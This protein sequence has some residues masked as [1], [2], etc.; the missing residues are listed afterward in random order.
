MLTQL[1]QVNRLSPA[2]FAAQEAASH[3]AQMVWLCASQASQETPPRKT[4]RMEECSRRHGAPVGGAHGG[5]SCVHYCHVPSSAT[6][7]KHH[8]G[9]NDQH[10]NIETNKH[11]SALRTLLV[12]CAYLLIIAERSS[13]SQI[14][15]QHKQK[16][17]TSRTLSP[18]SLVCTLRTPTWPSDTAGCDASS[19]RPP[20]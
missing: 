16:N 2:H 13:P 5:Q 19:L 9:A 6:T 17:V 11:T 3:R 14:D 4:T 1:D 18:A 10:A 20:L 12:L 15:T 8:E 7:T